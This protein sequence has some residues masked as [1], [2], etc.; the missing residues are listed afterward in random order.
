MYDQVNFGFYVKADRTD[1]A[2]TKVNAMAGV[3]I[4]HANQSINQR[5][6]IGMNA[7][8]NN[9]VALDAALLL[10]NTSKQTAIVYVSSPA[11]TFGV[12]RPA[13]EAKPITDEGAQFF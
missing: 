4:S 2:V 1:I 11:L 6:W 10:K 5:E 3:T 9:S 8:V 13:L 7:R 12:A